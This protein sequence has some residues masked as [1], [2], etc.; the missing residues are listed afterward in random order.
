MN[1]T[2]QC[3]VHIKEFVKFFKKK[4]NKKSNVISDPKT[5]SYSFKKLIDNLIPDNKFKKTKTY[6]AP[7]DFKKK[8]STLNPLFEGIAANDSK[9]LINFIVMTLHEEL[10]LANDVINI[11]SLNV[12]QSN[13][14]A[15]FQE[16]IKDFQMRYKSI[17]SELFYGANYN[18]TKCT[19][20]GIQLYNF[21]VYFFL[22]FPLEEVRKF[23]YQ[24]NNNQFNQFMM[25]NNNNNNINNVVDIYQC[26]E[27]DRRI[28][29]MSG[30]N[31]MFCNMCQ[32]SNDCNICTNLVYAP[33]ILIIILNRGQGKQFDVKLNFY[34]DLNLSNY[35]EEK[36]TGFNYKLIGVITHLGESG[37]SGHFIAFCRDYDDNCWY[38][39]NDA[40]VSPVDNFKSEVIDFGMPYLLFYQKIG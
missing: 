27:Y 31:A 12:D 24:N 10:N 39:F 13:K 30:E 38:K 25:I 29:L 28:C 17:A 9:D 5:L 1:A 18:I 23:V 16:F 20:C 4:D 35:I 26:F 40:I 32:K 8:I 3:F 14:A 19:V 6:Y 11:S 33:N 36:A 34:E 22:I 2:L 15:M 7:H 21:Q 37:M